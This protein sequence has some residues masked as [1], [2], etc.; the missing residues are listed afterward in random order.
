MLKDRETIETEVQNLRTV[1]NALDAGLRRLAS[2][3]LSHAI[4]TPFPLAY[5]GL[6]NDFN[7]GLRRIAGSMDAVVGKSDL[8]RNASYDL[9]QALENR[10]DK[11]AAQTS[12]LAKA[13]GDAN[14][15][16]LSAHRQKSHAEY[17]AAIAHTARLDMCE[18]RKACKASLAAV[19]RANEISEHLEPL[20]FIVKGIAGEAEQ[21]A[22]KSANE[23]ADAGRDAF[24]TIARELRA[25]AETL[26][27]TSCM[28]SD[29]VA[30][31][32]EAAAAARAPVER[33]GR[34][35]AAMSLYVDAL[36][37]HTRNLTSGAALEAD[38]ASALQTHLSELAK[39]GR[40]SGSG[41]YEVKMIL[42]RIDRDIAAID[43][44]AG[45]YVHVTVLSPQPPGPASPPTSPQPRPGSHLRLVK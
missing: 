43:Q 4:D 21:L 31:S 10:A 14:A 19:D 41:E 11:M 6:R 3:D 44:Q 26:S 23:A 9:R 15:L 13:L 30:K 1:V 17:A 27:A 42:D 5:E 7:R 36:D 35:I 22:A 20:V 16:V 29:A 25:L 24:S 12:M 18:P 8:L 28:L 40:E 37:E 39:A 45:R 2:G 33:T 38:A 32:T 34:E